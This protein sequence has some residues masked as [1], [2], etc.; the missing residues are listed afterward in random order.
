MTPRQW[1]I[2]RL[3]SQGLSNKGIAR[4]L[5]ITE[6]T[7]KV[8]LHQIFCMLNVHNRVELAML[9]ARAAETKEE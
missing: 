3:V 2:V 8:H 4:V 5:D 1:E 6:G 9:Y 7:V